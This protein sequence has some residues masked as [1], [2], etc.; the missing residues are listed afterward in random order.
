MAAIA[1][2]A[3]AAL[4]A[5]V[6]NARGRSTGIW[7]LLGVVLGPL[8]LVAVLVMP[9]P[10]EAAAPEAEADGSACP[11]C[12]VLVE[13]SLKTCPTCGHPL[14]PAAPRVKI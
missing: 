11:V 14:E 2:L 6:A 4:T 13:R 9:R 8:A 10:G 12:R 3:F 7:F 1:W 5:F